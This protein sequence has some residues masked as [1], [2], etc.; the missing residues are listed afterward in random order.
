VAAASA[1][2]DSVSKLSA[3]AIS[4]RDKVAVVPVAW[5]IWP[6]WRWAV[7]ASTVRLS[8][9]VMAMW[10]NSVSMAVPCFSSAFTTLSAVSAP[11]SA[12][13]FRAPRGTPSPSARAL[14]SRGEASITELNSSP[15]STPLAIACDSCTSA[16]AAVPASVPE[17]LKVLERVSVSRITCPWDLPMVRAASASEV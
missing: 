3:A 8:D 15:R 4:P 2:D 9:T 6:I 5:F 1:P 16:P 10:P 12:S 17:I 14:A 11:C 7:L 13:D